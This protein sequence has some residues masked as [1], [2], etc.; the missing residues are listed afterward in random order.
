M[1]P[2]VSM[3]CRGYFTAALPPKLE[4]AQISFP[5]A[6]PSFPNKPFMIRSQVEISSN[7]EEMVEN[8]IDKVSSSPAAAKKRF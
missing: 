5:K 1:L 7:A 2:Q 6:P 4:L 3:S 8:G